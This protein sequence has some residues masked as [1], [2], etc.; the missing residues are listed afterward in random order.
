VAAI[1]VTESRGAL[2][3][4]AVGVLYLIVRS[5]RR[6]QLISLATVVSVVIVFIPGVIARFSDPT[7][8]DASGRYQIWHVGFAAFKH[9][10][11]AGHGF[12]MFMPAY[13][14]A[15]LEFS[16]P[17]VG[18]QRIQMP[19]NIVVEF[20]VE[21]GLIGVALMLYAWWSQFR[22]LREIGP[23]EGGWFDARL[24]VE[25]TTLALFVSALSL[26]LLTFKYL[27]LAISA[28]W[29][30]RAAYRTTAPLRA[31]NG[32]LAVSDRA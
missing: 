2:I 22:T 32:T 12:G 18:M 13:Q 11:F 16:Q 21:L 28:A 27:W 7:A 23:Q 3:A 8:G 4:F 5:R 30:L 9:H 10:W 17:A 15:F 31:S 19:H 26:D 14:S 24:A 20:A 1:G 25:A 6:W 29:I